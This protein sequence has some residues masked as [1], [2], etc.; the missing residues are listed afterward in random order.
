MEYCMMGYFAKRFGNQSK[1]EVLRHLAGLLRPNVLY[2]LGVDPLGIYFEL[3]ESDRQPKPPSE[4]RIR[5]QEEYMHMG[6]KMRRLSGTRKRV[7]PKIR[8]VKKG[9]TVP[10][11]GVVY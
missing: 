2:N 5:V 3:R 4:K 1:D 7:G 6:K 9:R 8:S 10:L 11:K